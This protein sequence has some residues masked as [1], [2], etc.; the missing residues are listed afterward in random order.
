[1]GKLDDDQRLVG[2]DDD[3][4]E[5]LE[6]RTEETEEML[7]ILMKGESEV[8]IDEMDVR[9]P[10]TSTRQGIP[11]GDQGLPFDKDKLQPLQKKSPVSRFKVNRTQAGKLPSQTAAATKTDGSVMKPTV[12]EST[13]FGA[14][15]GPF[16][17]MIVDSP[18]FAGPGSAAFSSTVIE[19]PSFPSTQTVQERG[20]GAR[21][22]AAVAPVVRETGGGGRIQAEEPQPQPPKKVSRFL[23]ERR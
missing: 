17:P 7:R 18:S 5:E 10:D 15:P 11:S 20:T 13:S 21:F 23:A 6:E 14:A 16:N 2:N 9:L 3:S 12:I 1:M 8:D 22:A 19:S 4:D